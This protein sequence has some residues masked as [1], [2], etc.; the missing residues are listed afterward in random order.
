MT[1]VSDPSSIQL[2]II[3]TQ[4]LLQSIY[5]FDFVNVIQKAG[6]SSSNK[7]L[8]HWIH[9]YD[10]WARSENTTNTIY[11]GLKC[12][13]IIVCFI[14]VRCYWFGSKQSWIEA[15]IHGIHCN[16][17]F[18]F[19]VISH[20]Q[21][22]TDAKLCFKCDSKLTAWKE[23]RNPWDSETMAQVCQCFDFEWKQRYVCK[24]QILV[25]SCDKRPSSVDMTQ[26]GV[27]YR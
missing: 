27:T 1:I 11:V 5:L 8:S 18:M 10:R 15:I 12:F 26:C 6:N 23:T 20:L 24:F 16:R 2:T 17:G 19:S 9:T 7:E 25:K 13:Q 21:M 22:K 4:V 14:D 3:H